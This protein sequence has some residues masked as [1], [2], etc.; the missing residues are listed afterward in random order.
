MFRT[1]KSIRLGA[2][3]YVNVY[4]ME[5]KLAVGKAGEGQISR[6]H[7]AILVNCI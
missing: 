2:Y 3:S 6:S 1:H 7:Y 5:G 4:P